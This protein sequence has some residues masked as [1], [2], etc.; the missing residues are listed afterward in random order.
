MVL[1]TILLVGISLE[2]QIGVNGDLYLVLFYCV[3]TSPF[4]NMSAVP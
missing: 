4:S 1:V 3:R 2:Y